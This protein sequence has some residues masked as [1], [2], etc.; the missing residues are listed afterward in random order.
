MKLKPY[1]KYKESG[2][3]WIG[4]IPER[5]DGTKIKYYVNFE[6]GG[7]P[8]TGRDDY[9]EGDNVWVTIG[10][11][12]NQEII[13]DS[14]QNISNEAIKICNVKKV[15]RGSLLFS[16]KL[17]V[18]YTAFAGTDLYT[19]EAIASFPKNKKVDLKFL[20]YV[21]K[22]NFEQNGFENIYGAKL[23]NTDLLKAAKFVLPTDYKEQQKIASYLDSKTSQLS[24][25]IEADKRLIELLKEKR[26][27]LI[28]HAVTKGLNPKA[29]MKDSGI[30]WIGEV[31]EGW[32]VWKL[33]HLAKI[34]SGGTPDRT[35]EYYWET[36]EIP[37]ISSGEVNQEDIIKP[38]TYITKEAFYN[39]S[40]KW[41]P[42][43]SL[44]LALAGQGKTK[45]T[46]AYLRI[47]TT[48]N[49]SLAAIVPNKINS[50][51]L[52]YWL[53]RNYYNIRGLA[54]EGI[55]DGLNL[56]MI[57]QIKSPLPPKSEQLQ[58]SQYL[59]K[60]T[61]KIDQTI[62]KIEEKIELLEE[63]K[64]SLIHHVVTG[65]VDVREAIA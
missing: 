10:D 27:A 46:V 43:N 2:V 11:M 22:D 40:A 20:S 56:D 30:E 51:Y 53:K 64:K 47:K 31:P 42:E 6:I 59:N 1:P 4:E 39:S 15:K 25:T 28:N 29:K 14:K 32:E 52:Y 26:T 16:F 33:S 48:G 41:I 37:W 49:Q 13:T 12:N 45:G 60:A 58:I 8:P 5:W 35:K 62:K 57:K 34:Y 18:G 54:G 63:F 3:Q 24:K 55:R 44:I 50:R 61:S 17:S 65:K 19:N 36:G 9:F 38:T 7:T 23:F 21:F